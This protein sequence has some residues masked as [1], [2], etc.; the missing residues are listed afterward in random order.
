MASVYFMLCFVCFQDEGERY[1]E[2]PSGNIQSGG[3]TY[4]R[5]V[6]I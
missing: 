5:T 6:Y 2:L 4:S 3:K 1:A